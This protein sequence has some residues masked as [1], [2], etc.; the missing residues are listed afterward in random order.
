MAVAETKAEA[1]AEAEMV[2]EAKAEAQAEAESAAVDMQRRFDTVPPK[3]F[4][5]SIPI[6]RQGST[7]WNQQKQNT[8]STHQGIAEQIRLG[9][10]RLRCWLLDLQP[11]G[12]H[13]VY[14][15]R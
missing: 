11:S 12:M 5:R 9:N 8:R 3:H 6:K 10:Y 13:S 2:V 4:V 14:V 1:E 15:V 7:Y